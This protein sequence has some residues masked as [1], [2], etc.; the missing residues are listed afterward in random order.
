MK[1]ADSPS[2]EQHVLTD[3]HRV[4]MAFRP[5]LAGISVRYQPWILPTDGMNPDETPFPMADSNHF[6]TPV[7]SSRALVPEASSTLP[8]IQPQEADSLPTI[9][10]QE[11]DPLPTGQP[12]EADSLPTGQLQPADL[13]PTGQLQEADSLPIVQ[14]Q[15]ADPLSTVQLREAD[16]LTIVQPQAESLAPVQLQ[17]GFLNAVRPLPTADPPQVATIPVEVATEEMAEVVVM[18]IE[19]MSV[20][21]A[22]LD[23]EP[24]AIVPAPR[25]DPVFTAALLDDMPSPLGSPN[26]L[27]LS[28]T[29]NCEIPTAQEMPTSTTSS[30]P[31]TPPLGSIPK[32]KPVP[33]PPSDIPKDRVPILTQLGQ[34]LNTTPSF[35]APVSSTA[36]KLQHQPL[37]FT[38]PQTPAVVGAGGDAPLVPAPPAAVS[39]A[40]GSSSGSVST[41]V[42]E[43]RPEVAVV[44]VCNVPRPRPMI[45]PCQVL[46]EHLPSGERSQVTRE[47]VAKS[48]RRGTL[49]GSI[50]TRLVDQLNELIGLF[51]EMRDDARV[52]GTRMLEALRKI[53]STDDESRHSCPSSRDNQDS[54]SVQGHNKRARCPSKDSKSKKRCD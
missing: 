39:K 45:K 8:T 19:A 27:Q 5:D 22:A 21:P 11:A 13:L 33:L 7:A 12:Q 36:I 44:V 24:V 23:T 42:A 38:Q 48:L 43:P 31:D 25:Q 50:S 41:P 28:V 20:I 49:C 30:V 46:L 4:R 17:A 15:D 51:R 32:S 54:S 9:Q 26:I 14:P 18:Q 40:V 47:D 16:V 52:H 29:A 2:L 10:P 6:W 53:T 37:P 34:E 35:V 1:Y 3:V